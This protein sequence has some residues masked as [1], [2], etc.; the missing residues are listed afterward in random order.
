MHSDNANLKERGFTEVTRSTLPL[1]LRI[2]KGGIEKN[3][4]R[5]EENDRMREIIKEHEEGMARSRQRIH[6]LEQETRRLKSAKEKEEKSIF[7]PH[8]SQ[9]RG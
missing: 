6:D 3:A 4:R 2:E 8:G 1:Q 7:S 9:G 5:R